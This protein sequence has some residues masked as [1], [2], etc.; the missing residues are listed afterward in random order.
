MKRERQRKK[1]LRRRIA[2]TLYRRGKRLRHRLRRTEPRTILFIV[3]C[4]RSGT[5][6]LTK[7]FERDPASE[8]FGEF[9][10]LAGEPQG[11][12][13]APLPELE[14]A[15]ARERAS[16]LVLKPLVESQN[17]LRL[18]DHFPGSRALW[19]YRH[20]RDVAASNIAR[21]GAT[22]PLADLRPIVAR[23]PHD[24]RSQG[25]S[26][27]VAGV[28]RGFFSEDMP[29]QDA[30]VLFWFARNRLFFDLGLEHRPDVILC[31]YEDLVS[32]PRQALERIYRR[33]G[34][35]LPGERLFAQVHSRARGAGSR[36]EVS[37][38]V[39]DLAAQLLQRLDRL[40]TGD[41]TAAPRIGA[42]PHPAHATGE[43]T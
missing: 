1:S 37:P 42:T 19:M 22:N 12:R 25:A 29:P 27:E 9:S 6:M 40:A 26:A 36:L 32:S 31:K 14:S 17:V 33:L 2:D 43:A 34:R 23:H 10:R 15:L 24:W 41:G 4:Q 13:L 11:I 16:L 38:V 21:F 20:Y 7:I 30:A 3:G 8:V 35:A 18:L 39:E 5:T 28:V